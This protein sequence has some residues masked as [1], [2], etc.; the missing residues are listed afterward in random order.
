MRY[1]GG[2]Q[3]K[4]SRYYTQ[5]FKQK[6]DRA[7]KFKR[8]EKKSNSRRYYSIKT[9]FAS[10]IIGLFVYLSYFSG[11]L[12][13]Q[14]VKTEGI[15]VKTVETALNSYKL[16]NK[17]WPRT[18]IVFLHKNK[19]SQYLTGYDHNILSVDSI[20]KKF[21]A[22][23]L[24]KGTTRLPAVAFYS[25]EKVYYVSLDKKI[26]SQAI[27]QNATSSPGAAEVLLNIRLTQP[28]ENFEKNLG[29]ALMDLK[30]LKTFS[31]K[32][33][34]ILGSDLFYLEIKTLDSL[35]GTFFFKNGH[36]LKIEFSQ[37]LEKITVQ[38]QNL[39]GQITSEQKNNLKYVDLR[40]ENK[41]YICYKNTVCA[42]D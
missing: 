40:I 36:K 31:K 11:F 27:V 34:K 23:I 21:P 42:E 38:I 7:R 32:T 2:K 35:G 6:L 16:A 14:T 20:K 3:S 5:D 29:T 12:Q 39:Y 8:S 28:S 24:I 26:M 4:T 10:L 30:S 17:W 25:E 1:E 37:N 15:P 18:N 13:I 33:E 22:T 19:F 9:F 41:A